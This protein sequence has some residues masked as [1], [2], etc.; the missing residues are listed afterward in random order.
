MS[1]NYLEVNT[2]L[3]RNIRNV[4]KWKCAWL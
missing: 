4:E 1:L 2:Y 3:P